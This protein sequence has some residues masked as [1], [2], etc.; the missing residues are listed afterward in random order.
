MSGSCR[1]HCQHVV[2]SVILGP[3][4][5]MLS[6]DIVIQD[7]HYHELQPRI[8]M[9]LEMSAE[10]MTKSSRLNVEVKRCT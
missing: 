10:W 1:T 8:I 9:R 2:S 5:D 7:N 4:E 6:D 3:L